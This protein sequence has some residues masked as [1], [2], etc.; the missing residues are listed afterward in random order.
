M[1][2]RTED[3]VGNSLFKKLSDQDIS[4]A[5]EIFK[6]I[7][8]RLGFFTD[9]VELIKIELQY[10]SDIYNNAWFITVVIR[11]PLTGKVLEY[12]TVKNG[13]PVST[14]AYEIA[15]QV[16]LGVK[17]FPKLQESIDEHLQN[18]ATIR[19]SLEGI[20]TDDE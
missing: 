12:T 10:V 7:R 6:A 8:K 19:H 1:K 20:K 3:S 4:M 16:A 11:N 17:S 9:H 15:R 2:L 5:A 18:L 13:Y 14:T